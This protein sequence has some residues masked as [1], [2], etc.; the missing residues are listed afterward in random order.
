[1]L[2]KI[3]IIKKKSPEIQSHS[4]LENSLVP[5]PPTDNLTSI[6]KIE[7]IFLKH[8]PE[9]NY[10]FCELPDMKYLYL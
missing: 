1:M 8:I 3:S 7:S 4:L 10:L 2:F 5:D 9:V 6:P